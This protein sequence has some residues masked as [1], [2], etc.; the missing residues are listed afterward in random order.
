[1]G[2]LG[3]SGDLHG[4]RRR[5]L[6]SGTDKL[7]CK[8]YRQAA[9]QA[10]AARMR[11]RTGRPRSPAQI[12]V[13]RSR[14]ACHSAVNRIAGELGNG[15]IEIATYHLERA[16]FHR[17]AVFEI[18]DDAQGQLTLFCQSPGG[19][20]ALAALGFDLVGEVVRGFAPPG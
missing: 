17:V 14:C 20:L 4:S 15:D 19:H 8:P 18:F 3:C 6:A 11:L 5:E 1:M 16:P 12:G 13:W 9:L 2:A 10:P 7:H